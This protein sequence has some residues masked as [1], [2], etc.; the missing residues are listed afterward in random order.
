MPTLHDALID[1]L[2]QE[3]AE[4]NR[5]VSEL[6]EERESIPADQRTGRAWEAYD[7]LFIE[8][9]RQYGDLGRRLQLGSA[10]LRAKSSSPNA[11]STFC[12]GRPSAS[13]FAVTGRDAAQAIERAIEENN[14]PER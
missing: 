3:A 14:V 6:L 12:A 13:Y 11:P 9:V 1:R 8:L 2:E 4:F 10:A 5:L 7:E